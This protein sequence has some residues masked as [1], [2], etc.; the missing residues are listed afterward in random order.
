VWN[1]LNNGTTWASNTAVP[2]TQTTNGNFVYS[3]LDCL[4]LATDWNAT[5]KNM[6]I[7]Y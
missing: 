5:T 7:S 6:W 3:S 1:T 4:T 2:G